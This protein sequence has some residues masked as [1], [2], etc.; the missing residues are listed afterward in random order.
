M[1][2][3]KVFYHGTRLR[4]IYPHATKWQV[5]KW[6]ITKFFRRLVLI[7]FCIGV[8]WGAF[9]IGSVVSADTVYIAENKKTDTTLSNKIE[10]LKQEVVSKIKNCESNGLNEDYG[11]VTFDPDKSGKE[12][13]IAS[14]GLLQFKKP[15]VIQYVKQLRNKDITGKEA[16]SL[17]LNE[18]EATQLAYE[19]IFK[20]KGGVWNWK[21][22][23]DKTGVSKDIE[24]IRK[25]EE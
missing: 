19:V 9:K 14:Y 6:K 13:N 12:A 20:V 4:D 17:A 15:T 2:T 1:K 24:V 3:I 5:L 22:C 25:L 7:S 10:E 18:K 16:I 23:A 11:L 8:M 21:N